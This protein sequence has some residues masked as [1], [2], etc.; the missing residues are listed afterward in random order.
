M[1]LITRLLFASALL[2]ISAPAAEL[3]IAFVDM[4]KALNEYVAGQAMAERIKENA[5][6]FGAERKAKYDE[7][8]AKAE[9]GQSLQKKAQDPILAQGER[10]RYMAQLQTLGKE[11]QGM[12]TE[13]KEFEQK[14]TTQLRN[15]ESQVR[16]DILKDMTAVMERIGKEGGYNLVLDKSGISMGTVPII[17]YSDGLTDLTDQLVAEL[18]K[19]IPKA[20][21]K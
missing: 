13:I 18:N 4:K 19:S 1:K 3:K 10:A 5:E 6:K 21:A 15:E 20:V 8:K 7:Y 12:E 14:R 9:G 2:T 16:A 11:L 17:M